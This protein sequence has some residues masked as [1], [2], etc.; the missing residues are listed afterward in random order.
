MRLFLAVELPKELKLSLYS[1]LEEFRN[2]YPDFS[3]VDPDNYHMTV[4]F[5][6]ESL[7]QKEISDRLRELFYDQESFRVYAQNVDLFI[8]NKLTIF[9]GFKRVK[10]LESIVEKIKK[11]TGIDDRRKFVPH[12]T[13]ARYRVPSKQ[14]YFVIRKRIDKISID[15]EFEVRHLTLFS[16]VTNGKT[17]VYK[18]LERIELASEF[19]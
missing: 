14:Q 8:Q 2:M 16:S 19:T 15:L 6:G 17:P 13:I 7:R 4:F 9:T 3:W 11:D 12:L 1:Q 18:A 10:E 5:F